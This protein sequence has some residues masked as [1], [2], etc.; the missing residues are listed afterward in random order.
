MLRISWKDR[1]T[2]DEVYRRMMT[3]KTLLGDI[4][5][6]QLSFRGHALPKYEHEKLVLTVRYYK[7]SPYICSIIILFRTICTHIVILYSYTIQLK[8]NQV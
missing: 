8:I 4:V 2:N 1:I 3:V 7:Y 5:R 6:R